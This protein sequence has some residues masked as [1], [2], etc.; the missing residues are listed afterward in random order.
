MN[1]FANLKSELL[2]SIHH[3]WSLRASVS[4]GFFSDILSCVADRI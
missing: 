2:R 3:S 4:Y 1:V